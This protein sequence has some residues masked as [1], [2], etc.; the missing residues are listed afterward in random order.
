MTKFEESLYAIIREN[1]YK[2]FRVNF[3]GTEWQNILFEPRIRYGKDAVRITLEGPNECRVRFT[4]EDD[5]ELGEY[6]YENALEYFSSH[7]IK[8][9]SKFEMQIYTEIKLSDTEMKGPSIEV[10]LSPEKYN[11]LRNTSLNED[12]KAKLNRMVTDYL[13]GIKNNIEENNNG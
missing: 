13:M 5:D 10:S 7:W 2:E 4:D 3:D 11:F 1:F 8:G 9:I 12:Q 6:H